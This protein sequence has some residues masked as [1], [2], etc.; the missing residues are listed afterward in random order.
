MTSEIDNAVG[1]DV[2]G[3]FTDFLFLINGKYSVRKI[4]TTTD[5]PSI[6]ILQ[7]LRELQT[8]L[9]RV[10]HGSTIAT[11]ALLEKA[12]ARTALVVTEGFKD[13]LE[14]G[15]QARGNIYELEPAPPNLLVPSE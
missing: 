3:T 9:S 15:R 11:N 7:G 14:I 5:D 10:A 2:G 1:V 4:P 6:G 12:G 8:D 13:I